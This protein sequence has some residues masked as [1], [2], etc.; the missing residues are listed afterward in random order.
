VLFI[1]YKVQARK[2]SLYASTCS[3]AFAATKLDEIF[4]GYQPRQVSA[5]NRRFEDHLGHDDDDDD[6]DGDGPRNVGSMQTPDTT[7]SPR[8]LHCTPM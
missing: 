5:L 4:S 1:T 2:W 3:W 7:D 8:T 6:D